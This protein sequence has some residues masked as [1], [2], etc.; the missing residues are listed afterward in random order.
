M[1]YY[2]LKCL[3][4]HL[5]DPRRPQQ[6]KV[7]VTTRSLTHPSAIVG[8][9]EI[10]SKKRLV[11]TSAYELSELSVGRPRGDMSRLTRGTHRGA[12]AVSLT[13]TVNTMRTVEG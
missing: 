6:A 8:Q 10:S 7:A 11:S 9:Q 5:C 13:V 4:S 1:P 2:C 12:H 3:F